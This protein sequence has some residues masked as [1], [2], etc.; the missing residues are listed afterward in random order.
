MTNTY[1]DARKVFK[2]TL[3]QK[4]STCGAV[5][6]LARAAE[7]ATG[8]PEDSHL[9]N[10]VSRR[11]VACWAAAEGM[12]PLDLLQVRAVTPKLIWLTSAPMM[13]RT[14]GGGERGAMLS[15]LAFLPHPMVA[16]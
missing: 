14:V 11:I 5:A 8:L 1:D 16:Q 3:R 15:S 7:L 6:A 12:N 9:R 4:G 10:C 2:K 13:V